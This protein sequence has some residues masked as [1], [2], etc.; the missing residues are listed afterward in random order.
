MVAV[1]IHLIMRYLVVSDL[2]G[3]L[4][5]HHTYQFAAAE[6][7]IRTLKNLEI[8]LI[9]NSSKTQAEIL[10][11]RQ[12]LNNTEPFVC[13][14]GGLICALEN[15][16]SVKHLGIPRQKFLSQL[17][18][19]KRKLEL[20]YQGFAEVTT[21]EV[22]D[23]TGLSLED[24]A[25]AMAREATEPLLWRDSELALDRFRKEL[26]SI[27]LHCIRGGRFYHV[28][29]SFNKAS[30]FEPLKAYYSQ[31]WQEQVA[32]IALGDSQNDLPML[33]K[34][35][36]GVVVPAASG[37]S[38]KPSNPQVFYATQ[39]APHGWQQGIDYWLQNLNK[40]PVQEVRHR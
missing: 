18:T 23:W 16:Q 4:L 15:Q 36:Y 31:L 10:K 25:K 6:T 2:D 26:Q 8:P 33:E 34:A 30:C 24:A 13:E 11:I 35:D 20:N 40:S 17:A 39:L 5:D 9:L 12:Q 14:N 37:N 21:A 28:M 19:I 38:L 22:S 29:G 7:A 27:G 3:T 1:T 32:I